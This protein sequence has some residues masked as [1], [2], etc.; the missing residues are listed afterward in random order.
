MK[1][2]IKNNTPVSCSQKHD[3]PSGEEVLV[4]LEESMKRDLGNE[5]DRVL[6]LLIRAYKLG[7]GNDRR[8]STQE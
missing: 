3:R 7:Y 2:L 6:Y 5:S 8:K 1:N 4:F